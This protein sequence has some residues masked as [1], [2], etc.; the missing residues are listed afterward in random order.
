LRSRPASF[1]PLATARSMARS[2]ACMPKGAG[3]GGGAFHWQRFRM[4]EADFTAIR[5]RLG[6]R[7]RP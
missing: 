5:C 2:S 3:D 7:S 6:T 1:L 4:A